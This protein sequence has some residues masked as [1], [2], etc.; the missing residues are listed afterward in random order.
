MRLRKAQGQNNDP[1]SH[2]SAVHNSHISHILPYI[3]ARKHLW[4]G[5]ILL[6]NESMIWSHLSLDSILAKPTPRLRPSG[7]RRMRVDIT[8]PCS[9][10]IFS[11]FF[12]MK[13]IGR[14]AMYR[15]VGSCSCCWKNTQNALISINSLRYLLCV[16]VREGGYVNKHLIHGNKKTLC[17]PRNRSYSHG[18]KRRSEKLIV[19]SFN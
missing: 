12:S 13:Y 8:V 18:T 3:T 16:C 19:L 4:P 14:F 15:L 2:F 1:H 5:N 6:L 9:L 7:L 11:R 17:I 10:N